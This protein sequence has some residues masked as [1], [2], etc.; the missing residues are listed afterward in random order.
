M[1][2][3][4]RKKA[5]SWMIKILLGLIALAFAL[6][7]GVYS[8]FGQKQEVVVK[9]NQ[10]PVTMKQ[11]REEMGR[12]SEQA[13]RQLGAQYEQ[14]APM[15]NLKQRAVQNLV[16]RV[17]LFQAAARLGVTVSN[18][19]LQ[20]KVAAMPAFQRNGRFSIKAYQRVLSSSRLTPE[21]FEDGLRGDLIL[22]KVSTLVLGSAQATPLEVDRALRRELTKV[23]GVYLIFSPDSYLDAQKADQKEMEA[24]YNAHKRRY[25]VPEKVVLR[26]I[27]FPKAAYRDQVDIQPE[28]IEDAYDA[29]RARY[30]RPERV[31]ARHILFKLPENPRPGEEKAAEEKARRVLKLAR[32]TGADFAAL[33]KRYSQ[34]PTAKNGGD[35]GYFT[36][37]QMEPV[38]EELV[39]KLKPGEVGLVRSRFGWH[40]VKVEDHQ[41]AR[42]VP[43]KEVRGE[44]IKELTESRAVELA[45]AAAENAF[46]QTASSGDLAKTAAGLG[47]PVNETPPFV[48]GRDVEGLPGLK[49]L[50][51]S[52]E[53]LKAGQLAPVMIYENG[54]VLAMVKKRTPEAVK[55][56]KEV[57]EDVR[58]AV[59]SEKA[60]K[61]ARTAAAELLKGLAAKDKPA[62]LLAAE[63][64]ARR[65]GWLARNDRIEGLAASGGLVRALF[66]RPAH[67]PV[68]PEPVEAGDGFAAAVLQDR[69]PPTAEEMKAKRK[70]VADRL[71]A[72]KRREM[73]RGFL[74]D[75][76]AKAD[77]KMMVSL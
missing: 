10:E 44:L 72:A 38:F 15:L 77:I 41:D 12:L 56:L 74:Q 49:S 14:L 6:S 9:V 62:E 21:A 76:R 8:Y 7:F 17:L 70:E 30:A 24:Y 11:L 31:H 73:L 39:F 61:A 32:K 33:A 64:G 22:Q 40:V 67:K 5:G 3:L 68:A 75:L 1:L 45:A 36:R 50:A 43:L 48:V 35:L 37:G 42:V 57:E 65:T 59:R 52:V 13:R 58:L 16:N 2:E 69:K 28:D 47:R 25:L 29:A 54:S 34:G 4:M 66:M 55:P 18:E 53:G 20:R 60:K 46:D 23:R 27:T 71:L 19:E 51:Q 63:K 26:Y